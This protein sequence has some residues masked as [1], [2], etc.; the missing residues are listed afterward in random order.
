MI[1]PTHQSQYLNYFVNPVL[2]TESGDII[3]SVTGTTTTTA[4]MSNTTIDAPSPASTT[5]NYK[6]KN[7]TPI[8]AH[9]CRQVIQ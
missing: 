9:P 1:S 3:D 6:H 4:N 7:R 5:K 2:M 8:L